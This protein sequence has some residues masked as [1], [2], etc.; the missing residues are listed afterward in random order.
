MVTVELALL[1]LFWVF[2]WLPRPVRQV[3]EYSSSGLRLWPVFAGV[4]A[5]LTLQD[6]QACQGVRVF[7][8]SKPLLQRFAQ[9]PARQTDTICSFIWTVLAAIG[10]LNLVDV[11]LIP[12]HVGLEGNTEADL[13]AKRGTSLP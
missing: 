8:D 2:C 3:T 11:Q 4:Q 10:S 6:Y 13:E 9:G 5:V 7:S 1:S 12:G